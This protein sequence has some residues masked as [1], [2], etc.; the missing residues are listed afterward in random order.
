LSDN[1]LDTSAPAEDATK[2]VADI[3]AV[4]ATTDADSAPAP[5]ED[6]PPAD[7]QDKPDKGEPP[8]SIQKAI[9][10]LTRRAGEAERRAMRAEA[11]AEALE[12]VRASTPTP[13][14]PKSAE[15]KQSDFATYDEFIRAQAREEAKAAVREEM[16]AT[17][18]EQSQRQAGEAEERQKQSFLREGAKQAKAAGIDFDE[19]WDTLKEAPKVSPAVA[20]Y[21]YDAEHK[22]LL[23]DFLAN[24][25][26]ELARLSD[27]P[28]LAAVRELAKA[29]V[30]LS[31]KP[32]PKRSSAPPPPP[33][34]GG[35]GV[36]P[37]SIERMNYAD[38]RKLVAG[39]AKH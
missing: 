35:G 29:E 18:R 32:A 33:T 13:V 21:L 37:Q 1:T 38:V 4:A 28:P 26:D 25:P 34:L 39:W 5:T 24:D 30:R 36:A 7:A 12:A 31:T 14:P 3:A 2:T 16:S 23:A 15:L 11:R 19:A 8:A 27:L 22:A 10:R 17:Q 6:N 20:A 9:N